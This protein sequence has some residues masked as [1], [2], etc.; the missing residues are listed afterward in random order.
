MVFYCGR[1]LLIL[2]QMTKPKA[3]VQTNR[4][5]STQVFV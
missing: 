1:V 3:L 4:L 2:L 5:M